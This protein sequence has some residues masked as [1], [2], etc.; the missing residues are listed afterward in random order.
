M[1]GFSSKN[2]IEPLDRLA[3]IGGQKRVERT[4]GFSSQN[5]IESVHRLAIIQGQKN[6]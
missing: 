2:M 5:M 1:V 3:R 6:F 4:V